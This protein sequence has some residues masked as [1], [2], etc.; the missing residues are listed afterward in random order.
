MEGVA[1]D[2]CQF[3]FSCVDYSSGFRKVAKFFQRIDLI[4][5]LHGTSAILPKL[6]M[7]SRSHNCL[8]ELRLTQRAIIVF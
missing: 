1:C 6:R 7:C 8:N 5:I 3:Q 4:S 2:S